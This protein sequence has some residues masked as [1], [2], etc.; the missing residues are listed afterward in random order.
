MNPQIERT[1]ILVADDNPTDVFFLERRL[2]TVGILNPLRH[3]E[4]GAEAIRAFERY[5]TS[6]VDALLP[7]LLFLDLKMPGMDGFAVLAWLHE[8]HWHERMTIV[9]LTTSDEPADMRRAT[10]LGAHHYLIKY[11]QPA[12]LAEIVA[13][14]TARVR[15]Q[16][17]PFK[18][19][20]NAKA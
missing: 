10:Q 9:V 15:D 6:T 8:R 14:A 5:D 11:P 16:P 17:S 13:F 19:I 1:P 2:H 12:R 20:S 7:W 18:A 4:D 3:F